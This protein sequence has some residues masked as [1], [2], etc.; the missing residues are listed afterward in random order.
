MSS[1]TDARGRA[2]PG[3]ASLSWLGYPSGSTSP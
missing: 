2:D 3:R 1:T